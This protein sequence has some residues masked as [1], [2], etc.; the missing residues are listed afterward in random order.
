[1]DLAAALPLEVDRQEIRPTREQHPDDL[2]AIARVAH[3]AGDHREDSAGG[4]GIALSLAIAKR[5]VGFI[6]NHHDGAKRPEH[7][8][9]LLDVAYGFA[10]IFGA[11]I[12][13]L[14]ARNANR[15]GIA[16]G[17]ES[18]ARADWPAKQIAHRRR[19]E[20]ALR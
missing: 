19:L 3:L 8:E 20:L 7:R 18:L 4:A 1:M 17:E 12:A 13:K 15:A 11:K 9:H 6:D 10:D 16:F 14:E 2:A 5:S